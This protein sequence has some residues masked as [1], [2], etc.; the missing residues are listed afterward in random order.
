MTQ[1]TADAGRGGCRYIFIA[2]SAPSL[3]LSLS[4]PCTH[5]CSSGPWL[6]LRKR[7]DTNG[8]GALGT[9]SN[10]SSSRSGPGNK[11]ARCISDSPMAT[12]T[13]APP[14]SM[15][16]WVAQ[17]TVYK[18]GRFHFRP[19]QHSTNRASNIELGEGGG[20]RVIRSSPAGVFIPDTGSNIELVEGGGRG[21]LDM[22]GGVRVIR[23]PTAGVFMS[24][25]GNNIELVE[26]V[27][28]GY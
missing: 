17:S 14:K 18:N 9:L 16:N 20:P 3:S 28:E 4:L 10:T 24:D 5:G 12:T 1:E 27:G 25:T 15:L 8:G 23:S 26:C 6:Q 2:L 22:G 7:Y 13:P 11:N 19:K 21:L